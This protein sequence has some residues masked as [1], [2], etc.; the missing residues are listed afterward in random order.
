MKRPL[1][2]ALIATLFLTVP[3]SGI[4]SAAQDDTEGTYIIVLKSA[5]DIEG[6]EKQIAQMGG[7]TEKRFT[8][9]INGLSVKIKHKDADQLRGEPN[10]LSVELDQ[11]MFALDTQTPTPSWGLDRIDQRAL[12]LNNS[13]TASAYGAGVDVYVVDTGVSTTHTDFSGRLRSGFS[14]IND[15]RGS[16]DCNGHGTHV[17]GTSAG[18]TYGIAKAATLVPVRV[19]DCNGSGT[20]SGVIAGLDWI[21]ADH[22][23]GKPAVANMSLGGGISTAL[24][25]AVILASSKVKF[26]LAAGNSG[27]DANFSSPARANGPNIYTISAM[28]SGNK[29]ATFSNYGNPPVDYA[30]P[31]VSILSTWKSGGYN[32]I[33]GTSMAAPHVAGVA[34]LI[35]QAKPTATPDEVEQILKNTTRSFPASCSGCGTGIV[36][37]NAAVLNAMGSGGGGTPG[38]NVLEKGVA[39]TNLS[40]STGS[41]TFYTFTVPAGATNLTFNMSGGSGDADIYVKF[42]SAPTSSSYDCRPYK[43]GNTESCS[44][45]APQA[46]TYH[47]MLNGYSAYSGVSLVADYTAGSGGGSTGGSSTLNNLTASTGNWL[48]YTVTVP[49]GM[50]SLNVT[51]S[52]GTGDADLYVRRGARPTTSSYDCRPYKNGNNETCSFTNP[53]A[54]TW[55]ISLR[56]Y[57]TFS[58]VT[59]VTEYKP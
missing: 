29:L 7:R 14:A 37:A 18:T 38:T 23:S 43:G 16:N 53:Q 10:V 57:S 52:G 33:S 28:D 30:A 11:P 56:A 5:N 59:L 26:V 21:I 55:Y 15:G 3:I 31:G 27:A 20:T 49:A 9:A 41:N 25:D 48:H 34:A 45:A 40:G 8:N 54:A 36:D 46:G 24:D 50:S 51:M 42:G 4:A 1:F 58:G 17:A 44:F 2:T 6:K 35:K 39:K 13:F 47:V 19:L 32:T 22:A 12:P